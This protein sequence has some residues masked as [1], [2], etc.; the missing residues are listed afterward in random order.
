MYIQQLASN[1]SGQLIFLGLWSEGTL[2]G[3]KYG[4]SDG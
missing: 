2:N 1:L 4:Q 3:N